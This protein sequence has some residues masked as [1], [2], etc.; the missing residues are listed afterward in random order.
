MDISS[1]NC[2]G[3]TLVVKV[4]DELGLQIWK[5]FQGKRKTRHGRLEVGPE[6]NCPRETKGAYV[7]GKGWGDSELDGLT[8]RRALGAV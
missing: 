8:Q 6:Q 3:R 4:T 7:W 5:T 2:Q 1:V